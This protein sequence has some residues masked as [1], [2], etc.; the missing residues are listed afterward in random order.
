METIAFKT[1]PETLQSDLEI[2]LSLAPD[3]EFQ[4]FVFPGQTSAQKYVQKSKWT[5]KKILPIERK[6]LK[7]HKQNEMETYLVSAA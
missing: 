3:W 2:G 5:R 7:S 4:L 1:V 6:T